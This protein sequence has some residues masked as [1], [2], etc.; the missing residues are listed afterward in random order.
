MINPQKF[1]FINLVPLQNKSPSLSG[2][3]EMF[4]FLFLIIIIIYFFLAV[5]I[6]GWP[7][8]QLIFARGHTTVYSISL[9]IKCHMH[10]TNLSVAENL[11]MREFGSSAFCQQV[12]EHLPHACS[13]RLH[14]LKTGQDAR[15]KRTL[16]RTNHNTSYF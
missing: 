6:V 16:G 8:S 15:L 10:H 12:E 11:Q 3:R 7:C 2:E 13:L 5:V 14:E 9:F 1:G 4:C